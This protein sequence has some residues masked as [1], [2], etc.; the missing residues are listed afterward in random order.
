MRNSHMSFKIFLDDEYMALSRN[1]DYERWWYIPPS[2]WSFVI[3]GIFKLNLKTS[4]PC[5]VGRVIISHRCVSPTGG[6][7]C[8]GLH[9]RHV[10]FYLLNC[11]STETRAVMFESRNPSLSFVP[12]PPKEGT[13]PGGLGGGSPSEA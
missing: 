3:Y 2:R 4:I 13:N 10:N 7:K 5:H 6:A 9:D 8:S 11:S 1:I 12:K